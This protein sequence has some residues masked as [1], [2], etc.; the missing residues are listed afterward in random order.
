MLVVKALL[1][2]SAAAQVGDVGRVARPLVLGAVILAALWWGGRSLGRRTERRRWTVAVGTAMAMA[3]V[4]F[5]S[6]TWAVAEARRT[7][8]AVPVGP[9]AQGPRVLPGPPPEVAGRLRLLAGADADRAAVQWPAVMPGDHW[10]YASRGTSAPVAVLFV[11]PATADPVWTIQRLIH[12]TE[13]PERERGTV[14][15]G[16]DGP[17]GRIWCGLGR[18]PHD[19]GRAAPAAYCYWGG[20]LSEGAVILPHET[21]LTAAAS[22]TRTFREALATGGTVPAPQA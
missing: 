19:Q 9:M 20:Q 6:S 13:T 10:F 11:R 5:V 4:A 1:M 12:A 3:A 8:P 7:V 17:D 14:P 21:E 16:E 18:I 2:A 15:F 22:A